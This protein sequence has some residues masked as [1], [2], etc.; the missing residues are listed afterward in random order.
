MTGMSNAQ[1]A[2]IAACTQASR[3]NAMGIEPMLLRA[4]KFKEWL[5][6]QDKPAALVNPGK[7][8][9]GPYEP[10]PGKEPPITV[11][12]YFPAR[13][14]I[15]YSDGHYAGCAL[16]SGHAGVHRITLG[17]TRYEWSDHSNVSMSKL[18]QG[19]TWADKAWGGDL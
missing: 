8:L 14:P 4:G 9:G 12:G 10:E 6:E 16:A 3:G 19:G 13:H 11:C 18:A 1:A 15:Q 5:D 2:L 7:L 17:D